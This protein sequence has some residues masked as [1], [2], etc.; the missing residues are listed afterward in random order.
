MHITFAKLEQVRA[1]CWYSRLLTRYRALCWNT[2]IGSVGQHCDCVQQCIDPRLS[3]AVTLELV[4]M[5]A[6]N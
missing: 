5:T 1:S 3:S 6:V 2:A 4:Y